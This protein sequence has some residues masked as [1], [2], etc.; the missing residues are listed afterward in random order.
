VDG[1]LLLTVEALLGDDGPNVLTPVTLWEL[2]GRLRELPSGLFALNVIY[3]TS[4]Q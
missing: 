2:T 4:C 1:T 3:A